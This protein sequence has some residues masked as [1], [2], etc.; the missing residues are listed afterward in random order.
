MIYIKIINTT[1]K[2]SLSG[3]HEQ[4]SPILSTT[5]NTNVSLTLFTRT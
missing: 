5:N 1:N 2:R 4:K 3:E